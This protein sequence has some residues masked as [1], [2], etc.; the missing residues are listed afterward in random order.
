M[1]ILLQSEAKTISDRELVSNQK[2]LI[3]LLTK[4]CHFSFKLPRKT[5]ARESSN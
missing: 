2:Y 1:K 3:D 4:F 5:K